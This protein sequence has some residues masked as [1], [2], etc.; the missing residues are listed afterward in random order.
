[1]SSFYN[2]GN[3]YTS[4]FGYGVKSHTQ[5]EWP[6]TKL[7]GGDIT[8][9]RPHPPPPL[10]LVAK[11][12]QASQVVPVNFILPVPH[13]KLLLCKEDCQKLLDGRNKKVPKPPSCHDIWYQQRS[14]E[15][16]RSNTHHDLRNTIVGGQINFDELS[17]IIESPNDKLPPVKELPTQV[18]I[19][20]GGRHGPHYTRRSHTLPRSWPPKIN[21][22]MLRWVLRARR[23]SLKPVGPSTV[24][25]CNLCKVSA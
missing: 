21:C 15:K 9:R 3:L 6:T 4:L 13:S 5:T 20:Q 22:C 12:P 19:T 11:V 10:P 8:T 16:S 1:M 14:N 18:L 24:M 17:P 23:E 7:I 2:A 25:L